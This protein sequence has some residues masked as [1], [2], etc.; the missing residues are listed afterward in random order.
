MP[1]GVPQ[2]NHVPAEGIALAAAVAGGA[3]GAIAGPPGIVAGATLGGVIGA[4][5]ALTVERQNERDA[6][7]DEALDDQI[8]VTSGSIG[9]PSANKRPSIPPKPKVLSGVDPSPRPTKGK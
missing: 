1:D 2:P 4:A 5:I 9:E 7:H 3:L 6:S 8:G